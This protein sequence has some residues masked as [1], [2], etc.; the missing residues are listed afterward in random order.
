LPAALL[1]VNKPIIVTFWGSDL[2]ENVETVSKFCSR[3]VDGVIVMN[4]RMAEKIPNNTHV[5]P[6]GIDFDLFQ[7]IEQ[8]VARR[9]VGWTVEDYHV[10]FPYDP[11]REVKNFPLAKRIVEKVNKQMN[12]SV[13]LHAIHGEPH[14]KIPWYMNAADVL[15]LTSHREGSPTAVKEALA[16]NTPVVSRPVGDV[17]KHLSG[18]SRTAIGDTEQSLVN[19]VAEIL[20]SNSECASRKDI[21]HLS[22]EKM[23]DQV[24]DIYTSV[25][26]DTTAGK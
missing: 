12:E 2:E 22:L 15:L 20:Q 18:I 19:A 7:P 6:F 26:E 21:K 8:E 25:S 17:P 14:K 1:H 13:K 9:D 11:T 10:L 24:M 4:S 3:F 23:G 16:C 5:V